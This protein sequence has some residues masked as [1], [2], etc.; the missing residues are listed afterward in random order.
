[1]KSFSFRDKQLPLKREI[2]SALSQ[3]YGVGFAKADFICIKLG[4]A[5]PFKA[6][7]LNTYQIGLL[8]GFLNNVLIGDVKTKRLEQA[9]IKLAKELNTIKGRK[10][11]CGL[12]VRGQRIRSN[13]RS[14][15]RLKGMLKIIDPKLLKKNLGNKNKKNDIKKKYSKLSNRSKNPRNKKINNKK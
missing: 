7:N 14:Q 11:T 15:K 12:P 10:H 6:D 13:G 8:T 3:V 2:R 5:Y 4:M 9:S 1:M